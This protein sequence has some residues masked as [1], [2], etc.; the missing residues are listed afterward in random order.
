M[1]DAGIAS[2]ELLLKTVTELEDIHIKVVA[3][4]ILQNRKNWRAHVQW[5]LYE[6]IALDDWVTMYHGTDEKALQS[7]IVH[8]MAG[9]YTHRRAC[10][11]GVYASTSFKAAY[12]FAREEALGKTNT[13]DL[14]LRWHLGRIRPRTTVP[15]ASKTLSTVQTKCATARKLQT[16]TT[17]CWQR[18]PRSC[19][20]TS[21]R[22]RRWM[23][24][25]AS[26][27]WSSL[28]RTPHRGNHPS[29]KHKRRVQQY[30]RYLH[31]C[32]RIYIY[33]RSI[34]GIVGSGPVCLESKNSAHRRK[35]TRVW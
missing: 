13:V 28:D 21:S 25:P 8:G 3:V 12:S 10:G 33:M 4:D 30:I 35:K 23:L 1:P 9:R 15:E 31:V 29:S 6:D 11:G 5:Y 34:H 22:L 14:V 16:R 32:T 2:R 19:A 18:M 20:S 27:S 17:I 24:L 26:T 7:I